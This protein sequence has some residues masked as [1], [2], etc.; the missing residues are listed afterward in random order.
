MSANVY[1]TDQLVDDILLLSHMP[2]ANITFNSP[3]ILRLATFEMQTPLMARINATRGKYYV[4]Y[5][6]QTIAANGLYLIPG[7]AV[8]ATLVNI[9]LVQGTCITPVNIIEESEQFSTQSPT[10]TSYGAFFKGNYIQILPTPNIGVARFWYTK[11]LSDLVATSAASR[12]TFINAN[13]TDYTV[14]SVPSTMTIGTSIDGTG[15]QPPFNYFGTQLITNINS[16]IISLTSTITNLGVGDW[17]SLQ[18]QTPVPQIPVEFRLILAQRTVV[19]MYELQG[20]LPKMEAAGKTLAAYEKDITNLMTP[21]V[22]SQSK[23]IMAV[24]GGFL[25]SNRVTNFS[26]SRGQ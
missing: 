22:Q 19:K 14:S 18:G 24:N 10:S 11:R 20:N 23:V 3:Q 7:D 12:I 26:T 21:R 2:G 13:G 16:N 5:A 1:T 17:I 25:G 6:D 9:E 15:D 4:T 8:A